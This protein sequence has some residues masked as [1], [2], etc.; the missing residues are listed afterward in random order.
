MQQSARRPSKMAAPTMDP[1]TMP[2]ICPPVRPPLELFAP[3]AVLFE[4]DELFEEFEP[5][6]SG[7]RGEKGG[8]CTPTHL[9]VTFAPTQH[10]SVALGELEAQYPHNPCRLSEYP[11][12][13]GSLAS[14]VTQPPLNESDGNAQTVKSARI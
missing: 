14:P 5:G 8:S 11:Q 3:A 9:L 6:K 12:L 4:A 13:L 1:T 10:E 7:R 2:A